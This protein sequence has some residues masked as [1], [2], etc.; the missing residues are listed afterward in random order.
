M[1]ERWVTGEIRC[2]ARLAGGIV[3]DESGQAVREFWSH[4][5]RPGLE[6]QHGWVQQRT[7][8]R[9][10][11]RNRPFWPRP[12]LVNFDQSSGRQQADTEDGRWEN[13]VRRE[14]G[15]SKFES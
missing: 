1:Q 5:G 3:G 7:H 9:V 2:R 15:Y 12:C 11:S 8:F 6:V 14:R 4:R 10:R 13:P